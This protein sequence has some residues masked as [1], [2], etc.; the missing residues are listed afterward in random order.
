MLVL[1]GLIR[2]RPQVGPGLGEEING[3]CKQEVCVVTCVTTHTLPP[4]PTLPARYTITPR[5]V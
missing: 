3:G 1:A 5:V 4:L 2:A